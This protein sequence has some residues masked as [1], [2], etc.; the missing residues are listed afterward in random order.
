MAVVV[1]PMLAPRVKGYIRS[2]VITPIPTNGVRADVKTELDCTRIVIPV[3]IKMA[4]Y[5]VK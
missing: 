1:V 5:P 3:P 4:I 2:I